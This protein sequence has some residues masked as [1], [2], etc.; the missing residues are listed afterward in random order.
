M[1]DAIASSFQETGQRWARGAG[2]RTMQG[3]GV[4]THSGQRMAKTPPIPC[5]SSYYSLF[6]HS[7]TVVQE[8]KYWICIHFPICS[9]YV[10]IR[11]TVPT[12]L[13]PTGRPAMPPNAVGN[14]RGL[15]ESQCSRGNAVD[16]G[17]RL[18]TSGSGR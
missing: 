13:Y 3:T 15:Q 7:T 2:M 9:D 5:C 8:S 10:D 11:T 17:D 1:I 6:L 18:D 14:L 12:T 4:G 16:Y